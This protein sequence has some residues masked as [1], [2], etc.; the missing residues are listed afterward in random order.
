MNR[1]FPFF[2]CIFMTYIIKKP[3]DSAK[4]SMVDERQ[5]VNCA[6]CGAALFAV[7]FI[8]YFNKPESPGQ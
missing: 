1:L 7:P 3:F 5:T 6:I 2:F 4:G 8:F